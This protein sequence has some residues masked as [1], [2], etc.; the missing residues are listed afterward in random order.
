VR[1]LSAS[2]PDLEPLSLSMSFTVYPLS[3]VL[4]FFFQLVSLLFLPSPA[5]SHLKLEMAR[6]DWGR[7]CQEA[8]DIC[9]FKGFPT[10]IPEFIMSSLG[11]L[12]TL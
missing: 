10:V 8:V 3:T 1:S 11:E 12:L 2:V 4:T 6:S 5:F 9:S 7:N